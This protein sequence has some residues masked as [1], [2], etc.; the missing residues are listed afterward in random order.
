M[1]KLLT[2]EAV[3]VRS[4]LFSDMSAA[5]WAVY[6]HLLENVKEYTRPLNEWDR[7]TPQKA[8]RTI[9]EIHPSRWEVWK[10]QETLAKEA[11]LGSDDAIRPH[12]RNLRAIGA[13]ETVWVEGREA[14]THR[15][16][17]RWAATSE[18]AL[19]RERAIIALETL[20]NGIL[21]SLVT[22]DGVASPA[23]PV[24]AVD[25]LVAELRRGYVGLWERA[26]RR[27]WLPDD[28]WVA[29]RLP[30]ALAEYVGADRAPT[31]SDAE[32]S[33]GHSVAT[34]P[35]GAIVGSPADVPSQRLVPAL[36]Q[37]ELMPGVQVGLP[38]VAWRHVRALIENSPMSQLEA[39]D[40]LR[41]AIDSLGAD[42]AD[43]VK[44]QRALD[45]VVRHETGM[46][47]ASLLGEP[48]F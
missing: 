10:S 7:V 25:A 34:P 30:T 13:I 28:G 23:T 22:D 27:D 48:P 11:L 31:W 44:V 46:S 24:E 1:G 3:A 17:N 26:P 39:R 36:E 15:I 18:L 41:G 43:P 14:P 9:A 12:L 40:E 42:A 33:A 21:P 5:T 8:A 37:T 29:R 47:P 35:S 20:D 4:G 38:G 2:A 32:P 45:E 6:L 19:A 16:V